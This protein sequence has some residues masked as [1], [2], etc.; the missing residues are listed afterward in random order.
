MS[1]FDLA[2]AAVTALRAQV[3]GSPD[4]PHKREYNIDTEL[5]IRESTGAPRTAPKPATNRK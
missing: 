1:R 5:V 3:E 4:T 2:R